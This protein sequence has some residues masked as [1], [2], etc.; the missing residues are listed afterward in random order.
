ME[1]K[2]HLLL[3][4][5]CLPAANSKT[6]SSLCSCYFVSLNVSDLKLNKIFLKFNEGEA[7]FPGDLYYNL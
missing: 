7:S 5:Q 4:G 6:C 2:A 1:I 3:D